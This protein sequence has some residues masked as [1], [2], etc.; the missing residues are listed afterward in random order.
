MNDLVLLYQDLLWNKISI[1]GLER[2]LMYD[3]TIA[4]LPCQH[5]YTLVK[6]NSF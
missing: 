2:S 3:N 6:T 4:V 5:T 1:V